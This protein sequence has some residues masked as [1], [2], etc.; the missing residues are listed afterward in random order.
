MKENKLPK[1][2]KNCKYS[3]SCRIEEVF[4]NQLINSCPDYREKGKKL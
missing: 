3:G 4:K 1:A 2:C